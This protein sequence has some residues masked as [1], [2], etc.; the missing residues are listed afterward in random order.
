MGGYGNEEDFILHLLYHYSHLWKNLCVEAGTFQMKIKMLFLSLALAV[1]VFAAA[2]QF[3]IDGSTS[4]ERERV[5][6]L[7]KQL[8]FTNQA[9]VSTWYLTVSDSEV[10]NEYVQKHDLPTDAAYTFLGLNHTYLNE[11]YLVWH[12][13]TEVRFLLGHEAGHMICECKSEDKA[14]EIAYR[15]TR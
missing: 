5:I 1:S 4:Y 9:M 7:E 8:N 12:T 14:N 15:L 11:E 3:L 10:F 13:D 2:P 6:R